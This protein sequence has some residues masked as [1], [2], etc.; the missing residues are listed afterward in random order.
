[1][2]ADKVA[3]SWGQPGSFSAEGRASLGRAPFEGP[4]RRGHGTPSAV[5]AEGPG[6]RGAQDPN[7]AEVAS[8]G[9]PSGITEQIAGSWLPDILAFDW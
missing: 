6:S 1:M 7:R 5:W 2:L 9:T 4:G 3:P 8:Q